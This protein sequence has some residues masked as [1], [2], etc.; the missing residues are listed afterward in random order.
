MIRLHLLLRDHPDA[1]EADLHRFYGVDLDLDPRGAPPL[2]AL[3]GK[4]SVRWLLRRLRQVPHGQ[5]AATRTLDGPEWSTADDLLDEIRRWYVAAHSDGHKAPPPH[6]SHPSHR[7]A[8]DDDVEDVAGEDIAA[9]E[10]HRA[11]RQ[12]LLAESVGESPPGAT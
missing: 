8:A 4:V 3:R 11:E 1:V 10:R 12:R 5:G 9:W 6:P 2:W 7:A